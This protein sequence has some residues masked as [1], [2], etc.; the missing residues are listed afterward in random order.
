MK[1]KPWQSVQVR[2]TAIVVVVTSCVFGGFGYLN[3]RSDRDER[4]QAANFQ[5]DRL[6]HRLPRSLA[7]GLWELN[8]IAVRQIVDG[9]LDDPFLLGISVSAS[10]QLVYGARSDHTP[11][12]S[13]STAPVADQVRVV[14]VV[15]NDGLESRKI[16]EVTLYLS[17]KQVEQSLQH[18]LTV[19]LLQ[20]AALSVTTMLAM[21]WALRRVVIRPIK[22]LG[23]ALSDVA[24]GEAD[25]SL[26]LTNSRTTEFAELTSNFNYFVE[27][28]QQVMGGSIDSVQM[29]IAKV[30]RGD[31]GADLQQAAAS[32]HSIMG[33]LAVMQSNLRN[34]QANE[35]KSA[36]AL[37]Q[38]L[39]AAEAASVAKGEFLANM[40]HEIRTPMNAIIGLSGL[41]LKH[42]MPARIQDYLGKIR[43]SG[44]HLL[45]IINDILDF[46]KIESG[47]MEI[48]A[49]P[50]VL[51][52]VI[53]TVVN[54]LSEKVD[55]KGL[56]LLCRVDADI[57]KDLIGDP[58]RIGQILINLANNAIKFTPAGEVQLSISVLKSEGDQA[59]LRFAV[60]DT[61]IGLSPEQ[62]G[63]LF[64]SFSQADASTTRKFGGTGLGLAISKSLAEAMGGEVGVVSEVG[65]G[66]TFWFTA[67]LGIGASARRVTP[68]SPALLGS[69]VLVVDD[70]EASA[71]MLSEMLSELGFAVERAHSGQAALN[72]LVAA[73]QADRPYAFVLMDWQMPGMDG[74][75][76]V[77]AIQQLR[78]KTT[79]FMLMVT[80]HRRQELLKGAQKLGIAHVLAKPV[81][82]SLLVNT[83]MQIMGFASADIHVLAAAGKASVQEGQLEALAGARVLVVEDN[84]INQQVACELLRGVGFVVDVADNGQIAVHQVRT[85]FDAG[86]P[87]DIVLMDMQM[88]VMDGVTASRLIRETFSTEQLPI[89]AMTANAMSADRERCLAAGMNGF[90]TKPIDPENLWQALLSW[91][92]PGERTPASAAQV[93][94]AQPADPDAAQLQLEGLRG[95]AGLDVALGLGRMANNAGLYAAMLRKFVVSQENATDLVASHLAAG[96][97]ATAERVAHTLRGVAGNLGAS[98]LQLRAEQLESSIRTGAAATALA[99]AHAQCATALA[100]LLTALRAVPSLLAPEAQTE[101]EALTVAQRMAGTAVLAEIRQML[102]NDNPEAKALWDTHTHVLREL[103]ANADQ[104]QAAIEAFDFEE[105]LALL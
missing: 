64:K 78:I 69:S 41:A 59:L 55:D 18:G 37:K 19:M 6:A 79:P 17:F 43:Q 105:A 68:P 76:T 99:D 80:A 25:L 87:Y 73:D 16:G 70:N 92:K 28:L 39:E 24:S 94:Q 26:R 101:P 44:E 5:I 67:R 86:R 30:A 63:K 82:G 38:A 52:A 102:A 75:Q 3:Y 46:S 50:F 96:D 9:E 49:V 90:V 47:K 54:L 89:V 72:Q 12:T 51:D 11:I 57:P 62:M 22:E 85:Q 20:F 21:V 4:L 77:Q 83:M 71:L 97:Q 98:T 53:D 10:G 29:A 81:S 104:V 35:Q 48:E 14:D 58:L 13:D 84:E 65:K 74:L 88:P 91:V 61:G 103:C 34:Y 32:E 66:S 56:E 60:S 40:S 2:F 95:V 1:F 45:G 8:N 15:Y 7:N 36:A 100:A 93:A 23:A 27:K 31:L 33:R 42:D